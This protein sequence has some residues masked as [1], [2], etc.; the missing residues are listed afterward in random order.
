MNLGHFKGSLCCVMVS[1]LSC[2]LLCGNLFAAD[3][4][5][6]YCGMER[7]SYEHSW[8]II[9]HEDGS[10]EGFCSVHCAAIDMA[11]HT[12]KPVKRVTVGDYNT[13]Q[14]IDAEK[15]YWVIGGDVPGVMTARAK[16]AFADKDAADSFI[17]QHGGKTANFDEVMKAS[18]DDMYN[19]TLMIQ[20]RQREMKTKQE[21]KS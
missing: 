4:S 21:G 5:C 18:F 12:D 2:L 14:Q 8:V 13:K 20:K 6:M 1:V 3:Q 17:S 11:L 7:A 9:E 15:A 10:V 19:D 16:W